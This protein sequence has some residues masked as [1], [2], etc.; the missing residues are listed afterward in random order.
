MQNYESIAFFMFSERFR[1]A[2]WKIASGQL[3]WEI[4]KRGEEKGKNCVIWRVLEAAL[5]DL[6]KE[7]KQQLTPASLQ[8]M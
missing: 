3:T 5:G 4:Q 2:Q 1:I 8:R 6:H 7:V